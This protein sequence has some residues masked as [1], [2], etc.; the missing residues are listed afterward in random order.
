MKR[1]IEQLF[2]HPIIK[3]YTRRLFVT[4]RLL[5]RWYYRNISKSGLER[6]R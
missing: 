6:H 3:R 5:Y 1:K 4:L 2:E